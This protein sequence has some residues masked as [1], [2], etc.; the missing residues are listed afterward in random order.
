[1]V[2]S[3]ANPRQMTSHCRQRTSVSDSHRLIGL[4]SMMQAT[5]MR[6]ALM[7]WD[8]KLK[9]TTAVLISYKE[10]ISFSP[11]DA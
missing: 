4:R 2:V 5:M 7:L 11:E 3:V 6:D 1:M 8:K 10:N 9:L